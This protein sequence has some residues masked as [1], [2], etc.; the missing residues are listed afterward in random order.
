MMAVYTL[1]GFWLVPLLIKHQ[2]PQFG[3]TELARQA[4]IGEVSFNPYTLRLQAQDLRLTEANGAPLFAIG[5]LAIELQWRSL[6]RR[7]WSFA[8]IRMTAPSANLAITPDGK[9]N[10]AELLATLERRPHD[11]STD[12]GLPRL[13]IGRL[14]LEQGKVDMRD[15]RAGYANS[16][17][18]IDFAL[19]NFSTLPEHDGTYTFSADAQQ[20]AKLR[21]KGTASMNP[22]RGSGELSVEEASLPELAVY[23]K[24]YTRATVA[25]GQLAAT[26]PYQFSYNAGKFE[27]SV[28]GAN[29]AL[30]DLAL[31]HAGA[32]D[33]FAT[34]TRLQVS[35]INADLAR[36]EA[37][38]GEV[39]ADGG[40]LTV[41]R[42]AKGDLDLAKLL[43][44]AAAPVAAP[45][46]G[47]ALAINNWK[48][49]VKQVNF[50]QVAISAVDESVS[51]VL[52]LGADKLQLRLQL[53]AE[54]AGADFK[55]ALTNAAFSLADL[56][57]TSG[58]Q[59]P[60]KLAQLGF[61]DG[62]FD[63]AARRASLGRLYAE[64]G[65][66][67]LTRDRKGE[68]S[69]LNLLPKF[70]VASP[71]ATPVASAG[72][73]WIARANSVELNKFGAEVTDQGTGIAVHVQDLAVKLEGA[74][75][76]LTQSVKFNGGLSLA[77]GGLLSAQG[78][79]VPASGAVEAEVR[80]K[81]LALAP[82]QPLLGQYLKLKIAGGSVSAQGRL[83]TGSGQAKSP[84]LRYVGGVDIAGLALNEEDGERF[85]QWR[86][87]GA[88]KLT[89]S[90]SPNL[91]QIP[92][93]RVVEPN[94]TLIIEN[95]RS[96]NAARLLVQPA[97]K[98]ATVES[99]PTPASAA[100]DPFPVR[101]QRL[102]VQNAKLDFTDLSLRPQFGAKIYE[103]NGV[104]NGLSSNR[105]SRS[106]IELDG[107]VDEFGLARIRGEL[108][109][110][111]PRDN[112]DVNV[113]FKNVDMVSTSPYTMKFAGYRVAEGKISL[114][115]Q[116]KV[117]NSQLEGAN[118]III[119]KL[120]LGERVDSPDAL[121]LP[122]E[123]AIAILKD[124]DGR[125][126]LGLPV[127]GN[128][129]DPQFSYSAVVWKALG[130]VLTKIV[131]APFR[132]LGGLLGVSGEKMEAIE[133]DPGSA[134]LLPPE[135]EKLKQV[136]QVL[137][138][139]AQLKLSVPGQYSEVADGA[140]LKA[141][142][143]RVEIARR[144]DIKLAASEEPGPLD[145][146]DRAVRG[147]L[148]GLYAERFGAEELDRQ[149]K[150]AEGGSAAPASEPVVAIAN[151]K[152]E[153]A[154]EKLP[155]WQRVGKLIQGEPQVADA[156]A[157][158]R[159]LQER[160][161]QN[162]PVAEDALTQLGAQRANVICEALKE[163]GVDPSRA[164]AVASEKI[165]GDVG[166]PVSLKLGLAAK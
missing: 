32:R 44:T 41:R 55:L 8:E 115:L 57:L 34:L 144:A 9:F 147:A 36:R 160:L 52:K 6:V 117:R 72:V 35:D 22:I 83:S 124:S 108:N 77:E 25:A 116:Y 132:A 37:T 75:S 143:V 80:V 99:A 148:R 67:Q 86:N 154:Q 31:A 110:F 20:G 19:N 153:T 5:K 43:V 122:L 139:R 126:D 162:Q 58:S 59:T 98:S 87:V 14:A 71:A 164:L 90:L 79:V 4:T 17:T 82:L 78:R 92:E 61:T 60:F 70:S 149:K 88:D 62:S 30:R 3:Q 15:H 163:A 159:K 104:V 150:V 27:A 50:D 112:T 166:K 127:S 64:G 2:V 129:N 165:S 33:A 1:A 152:T 11:A 95:D 151:V 135:R 66:L 53:T 106:Q 54:Q 28:S 84:S 93:L 42:D 39:R 26:L 158:Y 49:G 24:S 16:F 56:A 68:L 111:A 102:R 94:A 156:S 46:P 105:A 161:D 103:L 13:I 63:L 73:P 23:L 40:K 101:I 21:W 146:R 97:T 133:F 12:T 76:D 140:A 29:L 51:P 109:P 113:V 119:D 89:A 136:A 155:L 131:T 157:F 142:A 74:S 48:L 130:N 96:F 123:L 45:V 121:K 7:A 100:D 81:Q 141:R 38:V 114:D 65:Q 69:I 85:A 10:I 118:Q 91:L 128:M 137:S 107:R 47:Q 125:I 145:L 134:R 138:K 18:P 120:T